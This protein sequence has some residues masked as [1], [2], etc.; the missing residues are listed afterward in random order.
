[1]FL[2]WQF[3]CLLIST[4]KFVAVDLTTFPSFTK[5]QIGQL[6]HLDIPGITLFGLGIVVGIFDLTSLSLMF[7]GLLWLLGGASGKLP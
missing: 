2:V 7:W 3:T 1:M 6:L 4:L 5:G